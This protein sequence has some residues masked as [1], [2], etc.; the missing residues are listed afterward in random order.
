MDHENFTLCTWCQAKLGMGS[1]LFISALSERGRQ[2]PVCIK[3]SVWSFM[4][5]MPPYVPTNAEPRAIVKTRE[6]RMA[7]LHRSA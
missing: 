2:R 4:G 1:T 6:Q 7:E 5:H 3:C